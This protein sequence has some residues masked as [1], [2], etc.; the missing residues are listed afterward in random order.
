MEKGGQTI[1]WVEVSKQLGVRTYRLPSFF[2]N[3]L[4]NLVQGNRVPLD[5]MRQGHTRRTHHWTPDTDKRLLEA[6]EVYGQHNWQLGMIDYHDYNCNSTLILFA[7]AKT[8]SEDAT[9]QQC[10]KRY[11]DTLDPNLRRG[12]WTEDEDSRLSRAVAAFTD[13]PVDELRKTFAAVKLADR[14]IPWQDVALFVPGRNNNQCRERFQI[15]MNPNDKNSKPTWSEEDDE[16]LISIVE[17][18]GGPGRW[19]EVAEALGGGRIDAQV[20]LYIFSLAL[21]KTLTEL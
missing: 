13:T 4:L 6:V 18:L 17:G 7:V 10:Q 21:Y 5:C 12:A 14:G 15:L 3:Q 11:N 9:A 19:K 20:S 1:D 16:K 8:V 2:V